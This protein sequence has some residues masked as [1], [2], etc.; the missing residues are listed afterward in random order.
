MTVPLNCG[1]EGGL[2]NRENRPVDRDQEGQV[3][4]RQSGGR[5]LSAGK[6]VHLRA[7]AVVKV[8]WFR[9]FTAELVMEDGRGDF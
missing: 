6:P 8:N 4:P 2:L 3:E 5:V 7:S 1:L 9:E